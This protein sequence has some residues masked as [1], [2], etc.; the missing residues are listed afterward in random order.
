MFNLDA[1]EDQLEFTTIFGSSKEGWMSEDWKDK[2]DN[3]LP[4]LDAVIKDIPEAPYQEGT[5][6]MQITSLDYSKFVGRIAI[7]RIF[8]GDLHENKDYILCKADG[9][10]KKVRI[11][12]LFVF[13]GMG[14]TKVSTARSGDIC[15]MVGI[16]GFEI[17]D[18]LADLENPEAYA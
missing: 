14:K 5:P 18:T 10:N 3:I 9:S 6:Q 4:L 15:S 2:T 13:E 7:G 16:E 8:R 11:K 17:G 1:T 12:E